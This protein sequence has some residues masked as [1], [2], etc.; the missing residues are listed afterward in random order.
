MEEEKEHLRT[1]QSLRE[2]RSRDMEWCWWKDVSDGRDVGD[3]VGT[4]NGDDPADDT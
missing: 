3:G 1:D 2:E 4:D